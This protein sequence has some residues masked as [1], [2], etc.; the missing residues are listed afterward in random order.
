MSPSLD[1]LLVAIRAISS[2]LIPILLKDG[3]SRVNN[4]HTSGKNHPIQGLIVDLSDIGYMLH[5]YLKL[6][7]Q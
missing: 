1:G 6:V 3:L 7:V 4:L 5:V 2:R